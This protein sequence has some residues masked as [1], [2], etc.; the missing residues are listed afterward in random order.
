MSQELNLGCPSPS[1]ALYWLKCPWAYSHIMKSWYYE[2][3]GCLSYTIFLE[4]FCFT[5]DAKP[6]S[7]A[8]GTGA[9]QVSKLLPHETCTSLPAAKAAASSHHVAGHNSEWSFDLEH[10]FD[11]RNAVL[12]AATKNVDLASTTCS[13]LSED[14]CWQHEASQDRYQMQH[15]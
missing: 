4:T 3:N 13:S 14:L 15:R 9:H 7:Q 8:E 10:S 11:V 5:D 2:E 12:P 1:Q 6:S